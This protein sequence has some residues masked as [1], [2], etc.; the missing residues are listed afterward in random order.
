MFN[1]NF[2]MET[3]KS[4]ILAIDWGERRFGLALSDDLRIMAHPYRTV[5]NDDGVYER[6][7]EIARERGVGLILLG[8]PLTLAGE[9]GDMVQ[10][11][12]VFGAG[13]S[14]F[15][16]DVPLKYFDER[17]TT[18]GAE[19]LIKEMSVEGIRKNKRGKA[20]DVDAIAATLLLE[21]YLVYL[22]NQDVESETDL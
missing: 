8:L 5:K 20:P 3:A 15:I 1:P 6:I 12:R 21:T 18:S 4:T 2:L 22:R 11:V 19:T 7:A 16:P 17:L 10:K 14:R 13:L 9:E